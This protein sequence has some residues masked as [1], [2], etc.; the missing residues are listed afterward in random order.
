M[1]L[2]PNRNSD[3]EPLDQSDINSLDLSGRGLVKPSLELGGNYDSPQSFIFRKAKVSRVPGL[4]DVSEKSNDV[5]TVSS[6]ACHQF[7]PNLPGKKLED[8][9]IS[10]FSPRSQGGTTSTVSNASVLRNA[11]ADLDN[12][13][14]DEL[15]LAGQATPPLQLEEDALE[16]PLEELERV[17]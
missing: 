7:L 12:E 3:G 4:T 17:G 10:T 2:G 5:R 1:R 15:P 6:P 16:K 13:D 11:L 9:N 14:G 8:A